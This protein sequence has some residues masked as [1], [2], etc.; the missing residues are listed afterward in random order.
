MLTK[1]G[2]IIY[3]KRFHKSFWDYTFSILLTILLCVFA[4]FIFNNYKSDYKPVNIVLQSTF[5]KILMIIGILIFL[6]IKITDILFYSNYDYHINIKTKRIYLKN[7]RWKYKKEIILDFAQIKYILLLEY[8]EEIEGRKNYIF[9]IDIYDNELNAY[10]IYE[11]IS[12]DIIA[13]VALDIKKYTNIEIL[14][15]TDT[16]N[17][18]GYRQR[19][20]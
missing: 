15:K 4:I 14:D 20:L 7:G 6:R 5:L 13:K 1:D 16:E 3:I 19:I 9:K 17:Y 18:E 10:E 8:V 11:S 2:D 12:C